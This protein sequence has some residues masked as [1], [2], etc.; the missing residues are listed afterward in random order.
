MSDELIVLHLAFAIPEFESRIVADL[1]EGDAR[2][3][4]SE[5]DHFQLAKGIQ[6]V[7]TKSYRGI[8]RNH[9]IVL[10]DKSPPIPEG[11]EVLVTPVEPAIGSSEAI[12]A[13]MDCEPHVPSEWVDELEALIAGGQRPPS[14]EH[15]FD[16]SRND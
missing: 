14:F 16:N 11:T 3:L 10:L 6:K 8:V 1:D 7:S 4:I 15:P 2:I 13:A 9:A 5:L 12:L